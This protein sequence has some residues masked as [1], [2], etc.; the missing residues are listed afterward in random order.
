MYVI[1]K[2][3]DF[4]VLWSKYIEDITWW[5]EDI[6]FTCMFKWRTISSEILFLPLEHKIHIFEL[7]YNVNVLYRQT[8][9]QTQTAVK[10]W[11]M[12]S[13]ISSLVSIWKIRHS[14]PRCSFIWILQVVLY[15]V[16]QLYIG[17]YVLFQCLTFVNKSLNILTFN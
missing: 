8:T 5:Q 12:T 11:E 14:G 13:W 7:M 15:T 16:Y 6:D 4:Q 1:I 3:R 9:T 2:F 17:P 10:K